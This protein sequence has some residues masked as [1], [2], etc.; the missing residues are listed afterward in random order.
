MIIGI[1][2]LKYSGKDT[3]A[4]YLCEKHGFVKKSFADP[5]KK[6][7]QEL[8]GFTDEQLWGKEKEKTDEYWGVS[9][10]KVLQIFGSEMIRDNL[11]NF[12]TDLKWVKNEFWIKCFEK[13][14]MD[15][16]DKDVVVPDVRYI[17]EAQ[18]IWKHHGIVI[19]VNRNTIDNKD[20]HKSEQDIKLIDADFELSNNDTLDH[21][22]YDV[23]GIL[24]VI[25][26][27]Q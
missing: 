6:G 10:R 17:N 19:R 14:Y 23:H 4:D 11:S 21:L 8:F 24:S 18:T 12:I 9:A 22:Y 2:G 25:E 5:L 26:N 16:T 13:W 7:V 3:I 1:T 15:N 27:K 20:S